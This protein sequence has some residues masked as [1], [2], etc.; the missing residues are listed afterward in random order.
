MKR[1]IF[2][3]LFAFFYFSLFSQIKSSYR[4]E[5]FGSA[6][7]GEH[8]PFWT[9]NRNWGV[10]PLDANN[11]YLRGS[12]HH[13]QTLNK[14]WAWEAGVDFIGAKSPNYGNPWIQQ[15]YGRLKWK[16]WQMDIGSREDYVSAL[17]QKLSSGDFVNSNNARPH[18]Q[19]KVSVP[20]YLIIPYTKGNVS[21]KGDF[22][23]GYYDDNQWKEDRAAP[24][25]ID[26]SKNVLSHRKS[27]FLRFGDIET[28]NKQQF[29]MG[30]SHVAQWGGVAYQYK[31]TG[32]VSLHESK[33]F[34]DFLR[35]MMAMKGSSKASQTDQL[36]AAGYSSGTYTLKYDRKLRNSCQLSVYLQ[37]FFEDGS[38]MGF[39]NW[40]DNL[41]GAE[42]HTGKK[43]LISGCV[44]EYVY[45]KQQTGAVH[46]N[47]EMDDAHRN[48]LFKKGN[49][50][51]NYYNH[52][53]Y[54]HGISYFGKSMGTPLLLSP[55]YNTDGSLNFK[56]SRILA[57]HLAVEGYLHPSLQ[58][59][60]L[61]T[62]GQNW[63][64]Y[65]VPFKAVKKGFVSQ[66]ELI[67][68]PERIKDLIIQL[69]VGLDKGDFFGGDT[70][71]GGITLTKR[72]MLYNKN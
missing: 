42:F 48:Q 66:L 27:A 13:E 29:I 59:R 52:I 38:G 32:Y 56:G 5:T 26:Y 67:Y 7:T 31:G 44:F 43:S 17:N 57:F 58:Y 24:N 36:N 60:L 40:R 10:V 23:V 8:T 12:L 16:I 9:V 15:I 41:I 19:I 53:E 45:T 51:D 61:C 71:G 3:C 20:Q 46:F 1:N 35:M 63:G 68:T 62:T 2:L 33:N 14:D 6:A 4:V 69:S 54:T 50:N 30:I 28:K 22:A 70:F 65:Y 34:E 49:G 11:F 25:N 37:H 64:R 21:I 55:E 72:G 47:Y 18:P 39:Q